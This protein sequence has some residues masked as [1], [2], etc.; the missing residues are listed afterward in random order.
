MR[1]LKS[2]VFRG[3]SILFLLTAAALFCV[4]MV[5]TVYV[6]TEQAIRGYWIFVTG[7]L[8]F[9]IFQFAW[10]ANPLTLMALLLMRRH[11]WWALLCS[12][13]ALIAMS[14]AFLFQEIPTDTLGNTIQIL[15]RGLGFYCWVGMVACVFYAIVMLLIYRMFKRDYERHN[16][17]PSSILISD[18]PTST[19]K[20]VP[21]QP[22][23]SYPP[24]VI[25]TRSNP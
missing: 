6:T 9:L 16:Q 11:P 22:P 8:G 21:P 14:Q 5:D 13:L 19:L 25:S 15:S 10:Y 2:S 17:L 23:L 20:P 12:I 1:D 3:L 7:W 24:G 18:A 4:A